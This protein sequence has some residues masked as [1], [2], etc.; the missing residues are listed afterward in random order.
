MELTGYFFLKKISACCLIVM[1]RHDSKSTCV[2]F[3]ECDVKEIS[4]KVFKI[5]AVVRLSIL[6]VLYFSAHATSLGFVAIRLERGI[7]KIHCF[8]SIF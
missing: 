1:L 3:V 4:V 2:G 7:C 5:F 6:K 8:T